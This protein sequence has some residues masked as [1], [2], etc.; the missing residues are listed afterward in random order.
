MFLPLF[1]HASLRSAPD[2]KD[3]D[4]VFF[5]LDE[6]SEELSQWLVKHSGPD[7]CVAQLLRGRHDAAETT[8]ARCYTQLLESWSALSPLA[9][10]CVVCCVRCV[11]W[12]R[13]CFTQGRRLYGAHLAAFAHR[14][15]DFSRPPRST[16]HVCGSS[17]EVGMGAYGKGKGPPMLVSPYQRCTSVCFV[18]SS[19]CRGP[20]RLV[21]PSNLGSPPTHVWR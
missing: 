9:G 3:L 13:A 5:V 17:R 11:C 21:V 14:I 4:K 19:A 20:P 7:T 1:L 6:A 18:S 15:R 12:V 10:V 2:S 8:L 16:S